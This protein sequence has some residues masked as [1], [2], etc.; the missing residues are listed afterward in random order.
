MS[1]SGGGTRILRNNRQTR[2]VGR[3]RRGGSSFGFFASVCSWGVQV[4]VALALGNPS[5]PPPLTGT[6]VPY[7][8][9]PERNVRSRGGRCRRRPPRIP[10]PHPYTTTLQPA[11]EIGSWL[12]VVRGYRSPHHAPTR[13]PPLHH[14][15]PPGETEPSP[16]SYLCAYKLAVPLSFR[17]VSSLSKNVS[18]KQ[19]PFSRKG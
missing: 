14:P 11:L 6:V 18:P 9:G 10:V 4:G 15:H 13:G 19:T 3:G 1:P 2:R 12:D 5:L 8:G 7:P 17:Y 16:L